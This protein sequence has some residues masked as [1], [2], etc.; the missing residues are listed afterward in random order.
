MGH[1]TRATSRCCSTPFVSGSA[2]TRS[3]SEREGSDWV[4]RPRKRLGVRSY[5]VRGTL[6]DLQ[7]GDAVRM[8]HTV[9]P[10]CSVTRRFARWRTSRF[11]GSHVTSLVIPVGIWRTRCGRRLRRRKKSRWGA[12][13]GS[14]QT[15]RRHDFGDR[16]LL[17]RNRSDMSKPVIVGVQVDRAQRRCLLRMQAKGWAVRSIRA[18]ERRQGAGPGVVHLAHPARADHRCGWLIVFAVAAVHHGLTK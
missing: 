16:F 6:R 9:R 7:G 15:H 12:C 5:C 3:Y 1:V 4:T 8:V 13:A 14:R 11:V 2:A 18:T 10:R 17:A